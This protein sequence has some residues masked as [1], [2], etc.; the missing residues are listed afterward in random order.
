[1]KST[2]NL[3]QG[4]VP[5]FKKFNQKWMSDVP[6]LFSNLGYF[7]ECSIT[8]KFEKHSVVHKTIYVGYAVSMHNHSLT[9]CTRALKHKIISNE[10]LILRTTARKY[11]ETV[12]HS[13]QRSFFE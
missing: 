4:E 6:Q 10:T 1:L 5:L 8:F 11:M 7:I 2:N 9:N 12:W 13:Q 3:Q